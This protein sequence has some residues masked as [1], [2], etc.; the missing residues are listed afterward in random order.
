MILVAEDD[1]QIQKSYERLLRGH[2]V[3]VCGDAADAMELIE[4]GLRPDLII[5]DLEMPRMLGSSFCNAVRAMGLSTPFLLVSGAFG[6]EEL[7]KSCGAD[8]FAQKGL[9]GTEKIREFV[10][11]Y[12]KTQ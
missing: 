6:L 9:D 4:E 12:C 5:S 1:K 7:A 11:R 8:G 3:R 10:G 2:E